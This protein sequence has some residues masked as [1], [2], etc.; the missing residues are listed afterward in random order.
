[1]AP[2]A[3]GAP[4]TT[5]ITT[6]CADACRA[7]ATGLLQPHMVS[8]QMLGL[9]PGNIQGLDSFWQA[10]AVFVRAHPP[11]ATIL[12]AVLADLTS[13]YPPPVQEEALRGWRQEIVAHIAASGADRAVMGMYL[14]ALQRLYRAEPA[15]AAA[16]CWELPIELLKVPRLAQR[17]AACDAAVITRGAPMGPAGAA[18]TEALKLALALAASHARRRCW[19][20]AT[21]GLPRDAAALEVIATSQVMA[22]RQT[23]L[24]GRPDTAAEADVLLAI[25]LVS[26]QQGQSWAFRTLLGHDEAVRSHGDAAAKLAALVRQLSDGETVVGEAAYPSLT[27]EERA[28]LSAF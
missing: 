15:V 17:A 22:W 7:L 16:R 12:S 26:A 23:L 28:T 18:S 5:T 3:A 1:M 2:A 9:Q 10:A 8:P 21:A 20:D 25:Q 27:E 11:A 13:A 24:V 4:A 14:L 6:S 19:P